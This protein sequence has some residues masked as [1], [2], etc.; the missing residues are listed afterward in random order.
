MNRINLFDLQP[1]ISGA[2]TA[3]PGFYSF[4]AETETN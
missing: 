4:L 2:M 3:E 1:I